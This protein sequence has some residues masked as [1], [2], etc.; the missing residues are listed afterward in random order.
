MA[1]IELW[2]SQKIVEETQGVTGTRVFRA[3]YATWRTDCPKM[4]SEFPGYS[5][6]KLKRRQID[7][8][9][10]SA[11]GNAPADIVKVTCEYSTYQFLED[12]PEE[13]WSVS[14]E[15][16]EMGLGRIW[17]GTQ[18]YCQ[19]A[20]GVPFPLMDWK[21]KL[22]VAS[23][24]YA[25]LV[26]E[27]GRINGYNWQRFKAG[28]LLF[29]GAEAQARYDYDRQRHIYA[30]TLHFTFRPHAWNYQ[31][32]AGEQLRID[33]VLVYAADDQP[34][35]REGPAGVGGWDQMYPP[36]Y[37]WGDFD[38]LIGLPPRSRLWGG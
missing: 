23:I 34:V 1:A 18:R 2:E 31:W 22:T 4:G 8:L 10:P 16:L 14:G 17:V 33:G 19:Q 29:Q 15:V 36:L 9:T 21:L 5:K 7:P 3:P 30:M 12:K 27:V 24:P 35:M 20:I 6:L 28:H 11:A 32:R 38:P 26:S 25:A 13:E 37:E